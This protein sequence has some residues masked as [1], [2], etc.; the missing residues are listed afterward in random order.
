MIACLRHGFVLGSALGALLLTIEVALGGAPL[1]GTAEAAGWMPAYVVAGAAL[2]LLAA[3]ISLATTP[4][5]ARERAQGIQLFATVLALGVIGF[6]WLPY[7][8]AGAESLLLRA[9][10]AFGLAGGLHLLGLAAAASRRAW[11]FAAFAAPFTATALLLFLCIAALFAREILP[12][13]AETPRVEARSAPTAADGPPNLLIIVLEGVRADRLGCYGSFR[14]T[15]PYLDSLAQEAVL[16]EQAFTSSSEHDAAFTG[17]LRGS[18]LVDSLSER[19]YRT[20]AGSGGGE[21]ESTSG[22]FA[23]AGFDAQ[24]D[25]RK[26]R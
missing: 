5:R 6:G 7:R 11:M 2:G 3:L 8:L 12:Y 22:P 25:A 4:R 1:R 19:G 14:A 9:L 23:L 17:L 20:W 18:R 26:P 10:L 16:F 24:E 15:T 13:G 21:V